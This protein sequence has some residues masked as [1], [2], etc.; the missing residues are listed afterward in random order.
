MS[1]SLRLL[2]FT[3]LT[4]GVYSVLRALANPLKRTV[5]DFERGIEEGTGLAGAE[6]NVLQ[7][8]LQTEVGKGVK[9]VSDLKNGQYKKNRQAKATE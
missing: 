7:K 4:I 1:D 3:L 2:F 6:T 5:E 8:M 9:V